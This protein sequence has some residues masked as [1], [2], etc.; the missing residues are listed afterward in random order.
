[1][2]RH[3][4]AVD[5]GSSTAQLPNCPPPIR[6][7]V[8]SGSCHR[9]AVDVLRAEGVTEP[10]LAELAAAAAWVAEWNEQAREIRDSRR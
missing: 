3:K 4:V 9:V 7:A 8:G 2:N 1:M 5:G 10:E 6:V